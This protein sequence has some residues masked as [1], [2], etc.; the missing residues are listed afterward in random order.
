MHLHTQLSQL[1]LQRFVNSTT[2]PA[3][4]IPHRSCESAVSPPD[5]FDG[6]RLIV[7]GNNADRKHKFPFLKEFYSNTLLLYPS[8]KA[9]GIRVESKQEETG[10]LDLP[11][12]V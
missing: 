7:T 5:G 10:N 8:V 1:A 9:L 6:T 3:Y 12:S 2:F 4:W 11:N